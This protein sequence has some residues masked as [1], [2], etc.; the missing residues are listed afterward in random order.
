MP[1][2]PNPSF[3]R[4]FLTGN[5]PAV[6]SGAPLALLHTEWARQWAAEMRGDLADE[7]SRDHFSR[8]VSLAEQGRLDLIVTGQQPGFLGGPLYTLY[9]ISTAVALAELRTAAGRPAVAVFWSGDDDDDLSEALQPVGWDPVDRRLIRSEGWPR[10]R[11]QGSIRQMVGTLQARHWSRQAAMLLTR[12]A[13]SSDQGSLSISFAEIWN[14]SLRQ[15]WNW[16]RLNRKALLWAFKGKPL[17]VISGRDPHLHAAGREYYLK[18][19]ARKDAWAPLVRARG[20]ELTRLGWHAQITES[21]LRRPLFL[22]RDGRRIPLPKEKSDTGGQGLIPGV[23]LRSLLQD[24]LLRPAAV[25]A[26]PAEVAYLEQLRPLYEDLGLERAP[27]FPRLFAWVLPPDFDQKE[28][29]KFSGRGKVDLE[30]LKNLGQSASTLA[31]AEVRRILIQELGVAPG[32]AEE[33]AQKR[34][35]RW[36]RSL[37]PMLTREQGQTRLENLAAWPEWV[38]PLGGRQER[39]LSWVGACALW[40]QPLVDTVLVAARKHLELGVQDGDWREFLITVEEA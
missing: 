14:C 4:D 39:V 31:A 20:E 35:K 12:L 5:G 6:Q 10:R 13:D 25:V 22:A 36:L 23:M 2:T 1:P 24:G 7:L 15:D 19:L 29:T 3:W 38:A 18:F 17:W 11:Q 21:S 8:Q 32:R 27:I 33:L 16:T 34:G 9:K 28:L 30:H 37:L 40:G 26:G